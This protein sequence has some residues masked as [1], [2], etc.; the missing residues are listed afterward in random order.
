[1]KDHVIRYMMEGKFDDIVIQ[2]SEDFS[3]FKTP[4]LSVHLWWVEGCDNTIHIGDLILSFD[5]FIDLVDRL[6]D[7]LEITYK[8]SATSW[9]Y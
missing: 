7:E 3:F 6:H 8:W 4:N 9:I 1:M 5:N 2:R